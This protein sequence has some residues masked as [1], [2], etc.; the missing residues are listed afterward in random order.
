MGSNRRPRRTYE[1]ILWLSRTHDPF[2]AVKACGHWSNKM[3]FSGPK[4]NAQSS[5]T[6]S[7]RS[8]IAD[9][10]SVRVAKIP[11]GI[12]H[13]AMYPVA[14]AE[15]LIKSFCPTNGTVLDN[16]AGSGSSLIAAQRLGRDL[17]KAG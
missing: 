2:T 6:G 14:L 5:K 11:K 8:W 10:I 13:T 15:I 3:A 17:P 4:R 16:F 1:E 9:V 7:G 12:K